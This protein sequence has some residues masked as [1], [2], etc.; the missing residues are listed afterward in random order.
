MILTCIDPGTDIGLELGATYELVR[1]LDPWTI[2]VRSTKVPEVS[3]AWLLD[4]WQHAVRPEREALTPRCRG[5]F[6]EASEP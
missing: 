3:P 5:R 6:V 2:A 4:T 1:E